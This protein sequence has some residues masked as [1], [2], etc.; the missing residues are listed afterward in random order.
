MKL[1]MVCL[2]L[3]Q[4]I[5]SSNTFSSQYILIKKKSVASVILHT[6]FNFMKRGTEIRPIDKEADCWAV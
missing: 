4:N 5:I 2:T 1:C 3:T 6:Y